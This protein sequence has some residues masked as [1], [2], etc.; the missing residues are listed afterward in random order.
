[1]PP[2]QDDK[3]YQGDDQRLSPPFRSRETVIDHRDHGREDVR[4][5]LREVRGVEVEGRRR[6]ERRSEDVARRSQFGCAEGSA[7]APRPVS[8][9]RTVRAAQRDKAVSILEPTA[10]QPWIGKIYV[11]FR[12]SFM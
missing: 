11:K 8:V 1:V 9:L 7:A 4:L 2:P 12:P 5:T 6:K 3:N 10:H